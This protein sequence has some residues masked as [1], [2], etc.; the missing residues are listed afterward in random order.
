MSITKALLQGP[1]PPYNPADIVTFSRSA[2][3]N[4]FHNFNAINPGDPNWY[5]GT[6]VPAC[7]SEVTRILGTDA[8]F[9]DAD[10]MFFTRT[11]TPEQQDEMYAKY[12]D[13][14]DWQYEVVQRWPL[15]ATVV[16]NGEAVP[17]PPPAPVP[18]GPPVNLTPAGKA[19]PNAFLEIAPDSPD[20]PPQ[21]A[22]GNGTLRLVGF[23]VATP[24]TV[25]CT[26]NLNNFTDTI[27]SM[28]GPGRW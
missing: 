23:N 22:A 28:G 9:T 15:A 24:G 7:A 19:E 21:F 1:P 11:S 2:S 8:P 13:F 18:V 20:L 16:V 3:T 10:L 6:I 27:Q 5:Y 12:P 17:P 14:M 4:D 26:V 25:P